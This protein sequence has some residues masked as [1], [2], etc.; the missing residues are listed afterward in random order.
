[1]KALNDAFS[2]CDGVYTA[3]TD[4]YGAQAI[5]ITQENGKQNR[6]LRLGLLTLNYGHN[7]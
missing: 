7:N 1:M 6:N 4:V 2:Y 5:D 3:L